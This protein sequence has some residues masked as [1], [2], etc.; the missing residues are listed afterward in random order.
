[1]SR[2]CSRP[3]GGASLGAGPL[4]GIV[5]GVAPERAVLPWPR[6]PTG[7]DT[8]G[9]SSIAPAGNDAATGKEPGEPHNESDTAGCGA[10]AHADIVEARSL[11]GRD[12]EK[13]RSREATARPEP[14]AARAQPEAQPAEAGQTE[15]E[16]SIG[17][18]QAEEERGSGRE[19]GISTSWDGQ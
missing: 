18:G 12:L 15:G 8:A 14:G 19:G 16:E 11:W 4:D 7:P 1:M 2:T 13:P 6:T 3:R 17:A 10:T 9:S 5:E